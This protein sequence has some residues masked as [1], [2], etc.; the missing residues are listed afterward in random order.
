MCDST[1]CLYLCELTFAPSPYISI[2]ACDTGDYTF[3][4]TG[5]DHLQDVF[6]HIKAISFPYKAQYLHCLLKMQPQWLFNIYSWI[7]KTETFNKIFQIGL[8]A[9]MFKKYY[10][11]RSVRSCNIY[12]HHLFETRFSSCLL[13]GQL[14][15]AWAGRASCFPNQLCQFATTESLQPTSTLNAGEIAASKTKTSES[16]LF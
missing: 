1:D 7:F 4:K 3:H 8:H 5:A 9:L 2:P 10:F 6:A 14:L 12:I 16:D 13:I 11:S 15:L